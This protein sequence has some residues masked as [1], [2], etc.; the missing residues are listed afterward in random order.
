MPEFV[1][2]ALATLEKKAPGGAR[3]IH[4]IKY[5]GYRVE[6]RIDKGRVK[7]L[8]RS[9]LDWTRKFGKELVEALQALPVKTALIDGEVVVE[10]AAGASDFSALQQA[11]SEGQGK[12]FRYYAFDLLYLNG[13]DLRDVPLLSRKE[14]LEQLLKSAGDPLRYSAHFVEDGELIRRHACRL[15]LEGIVSKL[16]SAPYRSGRSK[17]WIKSKCSERQEFVIAG[18]VPSTTARKAIGSLVLGYYD[19]K[20]ALIHAG[21][22]GTGFTATVAADLYK[23][24]EKIRVSESP[25][26]HRLTA[27]QARQ[28][29][30]VKPQYVAEVEFRGWTADQSLRQASFRGLREDKPAEEVVREKVS[31]SDVA[32]PKTS[33]KLTH[34]DR[35]YWPDAGVTK[36]GLADYY[37][38][39]WKHIAPFIVARPLALVRCPGGIAEQCFFQKHAWQGPQPRDPPDERPERKIGGADPL[40]RGSRRIDRAGAGRGARNPSLGFGAR[41]ARTAGSDHHGS[42]SRRG[43]RLDLRDRRGKRSRSSRFADFGLASFVKTTGGKG[44]HVVAPL[45]P[46]AGWDEV[47][48]FSRDIALS[49]AADAP[50]SLCRDDHQIEA[51]WKNPDRLSSQR[52]RRDGGR[53]LFDARAARRAG[54]YAARLG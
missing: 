40:H 37:A 1:E 47:K 4:E 10:N 12:K 11:L 35:L 54:V 36:A 39:V 27:D 45:K 15:S 49:M 14:T 5:D 53:A 17:D 25:F 8:T 2:P 18:F 3:W 13:Y 38:D 26:A 51:A 9:G 31:A 42:R 6:A 28:V 34:P 33:V 52:P 43:R 21:R 23:K 29:I 19:K 48:N 32:S 44:L 50:E 7:L 46:S 30:Y 16:R 20:G 22:V 24:L 41:D